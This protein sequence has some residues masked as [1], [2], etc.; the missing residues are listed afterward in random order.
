MITN[1]E[2]I[3][4]TTVIMYKSPVDSSVTVNFED[5]SNFKLHD[6]ERDEIKLGGG[7]GTAIKK[8][9]TAITRE[10]RF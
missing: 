6:L 3:N 4:A 7:D 10:A 9:L 8:R 2:I 5:L 1:T